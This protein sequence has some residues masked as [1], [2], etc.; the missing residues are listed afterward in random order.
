MAR[1]E[2]DAALVV[3]PVGLLHTWE[4]EVQ[5]HSHLVA[6]VLRGSKR[7]RKYSFLSGANFYIANYEGVLGATDV[8]LK[9]CA[10]RRF[11]IALDEST[12]IKDPTTQTA[13]ALHELSRVAK[14]R[15]IMTGTPVA[16]RPQDLWS[17]FYF[18][19]GGEALGDNY[20][21]FRARFMEDS[22]G[23]RQE[24][25][26]LSAQVRQRSIR[27]L[28]RDVL[29]LPGKS[30]ISH[31]IPLQGEQR[32][33]YDTC[34]RDLLVEIQGMSGEDFS[35]EIDGVLEKLVR[36]VQIASNPGL[37]NPHY[38]GP[39]AKLELLDE[40]VPALLSD[41]EKIIVWSCFVVNVEG[42]A[43]RF[44]TFYPVII[45]GGVDIE[46][47]NAAVDAIQEGDSHRI[48]VANP[49]AAREGLTLT[50]ASAAVCLD[51]NFSLIDY[52]QSQDRIHR[53]GQTH[54]CEIHKL[55]ATDT[56]DEYVDLMIDLKS[57]R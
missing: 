29:E 5:K 13:L 37:I 22:P 35:R 14:R 16:N 32:E 49:A 10:S 8:F 26:E 30:Y 31:S 33:I 7:E 40:L 3:A 46:S 23:Y 20:A 55:V 6:V 44:P 2:I 43:R 27:R 53:I 51:R 25:D 48:L 57:P 24:L 4:K 11:A 45:H 54:Q 21:E 15:V 42:V 12:R 36:L 1:G 28:K 19:D 34:S 38:G 47:R 52:L 41:H 39:C 56:I 50:R 17:Q 9:M 18:L